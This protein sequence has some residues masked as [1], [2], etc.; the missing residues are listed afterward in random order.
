M[1]VFA[2]IYKDTVYTYN[3]EELDYRIE[4]PAGTT[5]LEGVASVKP[6]GTPAQIYVNRLCEPFLAQ[7]LSPIVTGVTQQPAFGIFH[8]YNNLNNNLLETYYFLR[9]YSGDWN[10]E[11]KILS[12]PIKR[13]ISKDMVMPFTVFT[14]NQQNVP[15]YQ[16]TVSGE[17]GDYIPPGGTGGTCG[18]YLKLNRYNATIPATAETVDFIVTDTNIPYYTFPNGQMIYWGPNYGVAAYW[19]NLD[20]LAVEYWGPEGLHHCI[21]DYTNESLPRISYN[22]VPNYTGKV[23]T[24]TEKV[25]IKPPLCSNTSLLCTINIT[26][27]P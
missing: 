18:Y 4:F 21:V 23:K 5:I 27:L 12:D 7:E 14:E 20:G 15:I 26:Q 13:L 10:Y 17:G 8:L 6:D 22:I 3:G 24:F 25:Y 16:G 2:P 9:M 11:N 19:W 1:A